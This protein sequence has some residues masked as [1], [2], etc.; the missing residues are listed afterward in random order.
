MRICVAEDEALLADALGE[1]L[2]AEGYAVDIITDGE[3][4]ERRL[5]VSATDYDLAI[6]DWLLPN[7]TGIEICQSLRRAA[8][9]LPIL[10]LTG[11]WTVDD[12][13]AAF[14]AGVDDY[15]T[16]PFAM[17]ELLARVHALLRRP[18]VTAQPTVS[19]GPI[20]LDPNT[21]QVFLGDREVTLTAKEFRL[22]E[23]F[24]SHPDQVLSRVQLA[25]HLWGSD[26]PHTSNIIDVH[27]KNLRH[28]LTDGRRRYIETIRGLGYR[29]RA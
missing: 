10:M 4:A 8:S 16:K 28:K 24:L 29:L 3:R 11:R 9:Q 25:D 22:L 2:R 19:F 27:I 12:K 7:R 5:A 20:T 13:V 15:L 6:I 1:A 14:A 23:L 21:R 26:A 18:P 17:Q